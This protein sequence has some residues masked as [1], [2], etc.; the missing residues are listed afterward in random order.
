MLNDLVDTVLPCLTLHQHCHREDFNLPE[1]LGDLDDPSHVSSLFRPESL[2]WTFRHR[3]AT[4][5]RDMIYG[6]LSLL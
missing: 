3:E 5:P 6:I 2:L 4:D 1:V